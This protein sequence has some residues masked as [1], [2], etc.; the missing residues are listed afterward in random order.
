MNPLAI[1]V[2]KEIGVNI[3]H[4]RSKSLKEVDKEEFD[5]VITVCNSAKEKCTYFASGKKHIHE[6]F[7]DPSSYEGAEKEKP[8]LFRK[9]KDDIKS[10]IKETFG[11]GEP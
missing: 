4:Q 1:E 8:E 11:E 6:S 7:P 9:V 3:S 5:Y 10:W 2:M